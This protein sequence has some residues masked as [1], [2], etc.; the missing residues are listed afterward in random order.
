MGAF[1]HLVAFDESRS[2]FAHLHPAEADLMKLPDA[3]QP[4]LNFK[5]TIPRAGHYVVWA[6]VNL[7][8]NETF[9]PF[10]LEVK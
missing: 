5:L 7:G 8:G 10:D 9:V 2:G 3:Q 6:Q 1:A 4:V